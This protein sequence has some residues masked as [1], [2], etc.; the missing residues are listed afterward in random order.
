MT[1]VTSDSLTPCYAVTE[2]GIPSYNWW[3]CN[4]EWAIHT[5]YQSIE[6][7]NHAILDKV[8][9]GQVRGL[10][11]LLLSYLLFNVDHTWPLETA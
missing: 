9:Y 7:A 2:W 10:K 6:N 3:N 8:G 1:K 11:G 4:F 5:F